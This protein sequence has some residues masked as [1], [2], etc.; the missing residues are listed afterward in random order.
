LRGMTR[1]QLADFL[2]DKNVTI[3]PSVSKYCRHFNGHCGASLEELETALQVISWHFSRPQFTIVNLRK[4]IESFQQAILNRER[5][6]EYHFKMELLKVTCGDD[7]FFAEVSAEEV[8][9]LHTLGTKGL[10]D[11]YTRFFSSPGEWSWILVGAL[12]DDH[13]LEKL[14]VNF[15]GSSGGSGL[16][17]STNQAA[18]TPRPPTF[19]PGIDARVYHGIGQMAATVCICFAVDPKHLAQP[20][21]RM[22][23]Q[24]LA[25]VL[26]A[27]LMERMRTSMGSTYNVSCTVGSG[28]IEVQIPDRRPTTTIEFHCEPASSESCIAIVLEE[29]DAILG[30]TPSVSDREVDTVRE[31]EREHLNISERENSRWMARLE[32]ALRRVRCCTAADGYAQVALPAAV[33]HVPTAELLCLLANVARR[34]ERLED[35][36][37]AAL[38]KMAEHLF[39]KE[40]RSIVVLL[41]E[42]FGSS[43]GAETRPGTLACSGPKRQRT[44]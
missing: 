2:A 22:A 8:E 4:I 13:L 42:G 9:S 17:R 38:Q 26:E 24:W 1:S 14:V 34:R 27:R 29:I 39:R 32:Q 35:V 10:Q 30:G 40:R 41:P 15:F 5:D 28:S 31:K 3:A 25:E 7:P 43:Q 6:P 11:I 16:L 19:T 37:A 20:T 12:P 36:T 33:E 44:Q 18:P 23:A 21:C